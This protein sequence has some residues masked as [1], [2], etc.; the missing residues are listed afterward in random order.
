MALGDETPLH[1]ACEGGNIEAAECLIKYGA[2][3]D[4]QTNVIYPFYDI[5]LSL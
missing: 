3:T 4:I 1:K 5:Y 2:Q